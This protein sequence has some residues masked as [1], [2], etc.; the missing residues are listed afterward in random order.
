MLYRRGSIWWYRLKFAGT[1]IRESTKSRNKDLARRAE[2]QR[3][4][5]LEEGF[6]Q[7][8]K[9]QAPLAFSQAFDQWLE[10]R[11]MTFAPKTVQIEQTNMAHL[12]PCFGQ[13]LL[14]DLQ[15]QDLA[16]YQRGRLRDGAA[17]KTI[18]L[19]LGTVRAVL[20]RHRLWAALQPDVHFLATRD[21]HGKALSLDEEQALL[22]ACRDSR[23]V[24]L[25]PAVVLAITSGMRYRE[26]LTLQWSNVD[27]G[28]RRLIV[29]Q[30]K[31]EA[32]TGRG[33]PLNDHAHA[34]L[35]FLHGRFGETDP[36]HYVFAYERYGLAGDTPCTYN[37]DPT[38]PLK[39]LK[40]AWESAK[41]RSGVTCRFHDLRH[42]AATR[43]LEGGT[44]LIVVAS[45]LGW[46]AST[47][48]RMAKRYGHISHDTLAQA[49][50]LLTP[51]TAIE[52][53]LHQGGGHRKGHSPEAPSLSNHR[54]LLK[55]DG[56]SGWIRTS[57]P[58]VN[59]RM[60]CR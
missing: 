38:R 2:R 43:L 47:T 7:L 30:S 13:R 3:R 36:A 52:D 8:P 46:S 60:L 6:N 5:T 37:A 10:D 15:P 56:S 31:T 16:T 58:P 57:N 23:S 53:L 59:S 25:L 39:S 18:N 24:A 22:G 50:R 45:L 17:P 9:R 21:D 20:R 44:P 28:R 54:K 1:E 14:T 26:V 33:V 41:R 35:T 40:E 19:E 12:R 4:H 29:R 42:T 48:A 51:T 49:V 32:G 27:L 55:R 34:V 11:S